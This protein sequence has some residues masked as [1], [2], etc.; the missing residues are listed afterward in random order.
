MEQYKI[1]L[2][3]GA[4]AAYVIKYLQ[5]SKY[6]PWIT[7]EAHKITLLVQAVLSLLVSLGIGY[8]WSPDAHTLLISGLSLSGI[9][10]GVMTW[11][12]QFAIQHGFTNLITMPTGSTAA[13]N[14]PTP[15]AGPGGGA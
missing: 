15:P 11:V 14:G 3:L 13:K 4:L 1:V 5:G 10:N 12:S 6:F 2:G 7:A 8:H 9:F